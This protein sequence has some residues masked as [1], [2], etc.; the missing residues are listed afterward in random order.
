[1]DCVGES[2]ADEFFGDDAND[3]EQHTLDSMGDRYYVS[4]SKKRYFRH[5]V[6]VDLA[7]QSAV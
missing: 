2:G 7:S 3:D 6:D 1:M 4:L 5:S